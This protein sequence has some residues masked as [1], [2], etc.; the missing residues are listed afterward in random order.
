V[1][2]AEPW[3]CP[4][5]GAMTSRP[6]WEI[7]AQGTELGVSPESFVPSSQALGRTVAAVRRCTTCGHAAVVEL[8]SP[9][10]ING[11][12]SDAIDE[13]S[14]REEAG[15][16][17]TGHRLLLLLEKFVEPGTFLDVGAWTGSLVEAARQRGWKA[18][19]LEP[20]EWAVSRARERGLDVVS[21]TFEDA[22]IEAR[23]LRGLAMCDVLE[24]LADPAA[25]LAH[26]RGLVQ[27]HGGLVLTVP[28]AGS[29]LA[30]VLGR[31]WWSV[32]PMHL[33]YFTRGSMDL[34]L[35][36]TGWEPVL[37]RSH[38][39]V[40]TVRY[41]AERVAG[42]APSAADALTRATA[43]LGLADRLMAPN[44]FDRMM[45]VALPRD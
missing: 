30:R 2:H 1:T 41:Y 20:S 18:R 45:I 21:S 12:Y 25:A 40:F 8:P 7:G 35:R 10:E 3:I 27:P 23:S 22:A 38:P 14:L 13:V 19:G 26:A 4:A 44:F 34:L 16:V 9:E 42:Y 43:R 11:A 37:T 5:C 6:L 31:R 39:K 15:Q 24:H 29:P 36:R 17:E 28:D 33:Q 32:L